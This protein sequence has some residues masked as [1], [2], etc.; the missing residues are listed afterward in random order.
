MLRIRLEDTLELQ[1]RPTVALLQ[2]QLRQLEADVGAARVI[3]E[4]LY[5]GNGRRLMNWG[6]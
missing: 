5:R 1:E 6:R 2:Q 3:L 4:A